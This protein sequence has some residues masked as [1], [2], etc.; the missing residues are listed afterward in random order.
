[1]KWAF[2]IFTVDA[3]LSLFFLLHPEIP[4][5][6][7]SF[8]VPLPP[9]KLENNNDQNTK[10][11][12]SSDMLTPGEGL[13]LRGISGRS[14]QDGTVGTAVHENRNDIK[15]SLRGARDNRTDQAREQARSDLKEV[16]GHIEALQDNLEAGKERQM[17]LEAEIASLERPLHTNDEKKTV[18]EI[19]KALTTLK[20]TIQ[21]LEQQLELMRESENSLKEQLASLEQDTKEQSGN[22]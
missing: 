9:Q 6:I 4:A 13:L 3:L 8:L 15:P 10:V 22:D 21:E 11:L 2:I 16:Q 20:G 19:T 1:M 18:K 14:E 17:T 12:D 5:A 7:A